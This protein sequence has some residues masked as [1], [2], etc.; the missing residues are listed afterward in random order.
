MFITYLFEA[1]ELYL[2]WVA[3]VMFSICL[4]EYSHART[5]WSCGDTTAVDQ[6]YLTL[7]P[8]VVMGPISIGLLAFFGIAW[9]AVP[10]NPSR[11]RQPYGR[12]LVAAAGPA[13]NIGLFALFFAVLVGGGL[14]AGSRH[15]FLVG[16]TGMRANA[17]LFLFNMLPVPGLDGWDVFELLFPPLRRV[18]Q[19]TRG[20]IGWILLLIILFT[21]FFRVFITLA[22]QITELLINLLPLTA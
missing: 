13:A 16:H 14:V 21:G 10:V 12:A 20:Q 17:F 5:A 2:T 8:L 3:V 7:N 22:T 18:P 19:E 1:P 6:G 11:L 9:G 15:V 4:H